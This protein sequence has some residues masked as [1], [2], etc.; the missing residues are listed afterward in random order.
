M[1]PRGGVPGSSGAAGSR[2]T[3][4]PPGRGPYGRGGVLGAGRPR[5]PTVA[6]STC[7][8]HPPSPP[9]HPERH[10]HGCTGQVALPRPPPSTRACTP[11]WGVSPPRGPLGAFPLPPKATRHPGA[12]SLGGAPR[13]AVRAPMARAAC[14]RGPSR[15]PSSTH[16][17]GVRAVLQSKGPPGLGLGVRGPLGAPLGVPLCGRHDASGD[18]L[19]ACRVLGRV[20]HPPHLARRPSCH[21][22]SLPPARTQQLRG[23]SARPQHPGQCQLLRFEP[24]VGGTETCKLGTPCSPL[25]SGRTSFGGFPVYQVSHIDTKLD[26]I[27]LPGSFFLFSLHILLCYSECER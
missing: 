11:A 5:H 22:S 24:R 23:A 26:K 3:C 19:C 25:T 4:F 21:P 16:L 1:H 15:T 12:A 13:P 18:G 10:T 20:D 17:A 8:Q 9:L 14:A 7:T 27:N 2:A 6:R